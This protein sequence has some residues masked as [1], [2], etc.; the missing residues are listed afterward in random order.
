M[1]RLLLLLGLAL[2]SLRHRPA[3][4]ALLLVTVTTVCATVTTGLTLRDSVGQSYAEVRAATD[5]PDVLAMPTS[6]G[7]RAL[8]ELDPLLDLPGVTARGG[9][10]PVLFPMIE[11]HGMTVRAVVE[12]RDPVPDAI[13]RPQLLA[14]DW[15]SPGGVVVERAFALALGVRTGDRL[16]IGGEGFT[17]TGVARTAASSPYPRAVWSPQGGGPSPHAGQV[18]LTGDDLLRLSS[19]ALPVSYVAHLRLA[20]PERAEEFVRSP[21]VLAVPVTVRSWQFFAAN[22]S[23]NLRGVHDALTAAGW[24]LVVLA[25]AAA[26]SLVAG[27]LAEQGRRVGLLKAVG[28]S[29]AMVAAVLLAEYLAVALVAGPAG[30]LLGCRFAAVFSNPGGGLPDVGLAAPSVGTVVAVAVLALAIAA[31]AAAGPAWRAAQRSTARALADAARPPRGRSAVDRVARRLPVP[32][33]LGL[34]LTARRPRRALLTAVTV[35]TVTAALAAALTFRAQP[36]RPRD[37]GGS[38]LP[39]P[40][41]LLVQRIVAGSV[42]LVIALAVVGAVSL[43]WNAALDARHSLAVARTLGATPGQANRALVLSQLLPALPA[44]ALGAPAGAGLYGL[45]HAGPMAAAG[46]GPADSAL[47][48][49]GTLL[50]LAAVTAVPARVDTHRPVHVVLAGARR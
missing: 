43:A 1:G 9:P 28:A 50:G 15:V 45:L 12:G 10:Y 42:A 30:L 14:G 27:R 31:G 25:S 26:S 2:R 17:V 29:P 18:W 8:R 37:L 16:T 46:P 39:D 44:A 34:R 35:F 19:D 7:E 21:A 23:G 11:A 41:A 49:A 38:L 36:V 20:E 6:T 22:A 48:V 47:L 33:M 40:D 5:G 13:D 3:Q 24:L 32:L 4:T